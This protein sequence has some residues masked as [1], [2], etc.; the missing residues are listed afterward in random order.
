[1]LLAAWLIAGCAA[2]SLASTGPS[3]PA[4]SGGVPSGEELPM[5]SELPSGKPSQMPPMR[6]PVEVVGVVEAGVESGCTILRT[7]TERYQ[8]TGSVD[9]LI[10]PGARLRVKGWARSDVVTTCQQ[11]I[12]LQVLEVHPE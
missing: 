3:H 4:P 1:M 6:D 8:L 9:P 2:G 11:G 10:K 5:F 7:D 12:L